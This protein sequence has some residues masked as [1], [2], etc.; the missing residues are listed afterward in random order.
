MSTPR[1]ILIVGGTHGNEWTGVKIVQHYQDY[2][3]SKY[4]KLELEFLFANPEANKKNCRFTEED[5]NRAFAFLDEK[6]STYENK[7]AQEIRHLIQSTPCFVLDLHTSTANMGKTVVVTH[8]NPLNLS[9]CAHLARKFS[10]CRII[11][12]PDPRKKYL[13]SQSQNGLILE[14]G[15]VANSVVA[16][17]TLESTVKLI[18]NILEFLSG[19]DY[20]SHESVELFEEFEDVHYP[21]NEKGEINAYIHSGFQGKD[22]QAIEGD[23]VPFKSFQGADMKMKTSEKLYPIF[24]NEAAYYPT[25]LAFTLCR[26]KKISF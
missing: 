3:K 23:Y 18:E 22:F 4:P 16:A 20:A 14:V 1:R 25:K 13:V 7:R 2:L 26:K 8:Y 12:S 17:E 15:P 19:S 5:L 9:L 10:D 24:I 21:S 6:R 11:G